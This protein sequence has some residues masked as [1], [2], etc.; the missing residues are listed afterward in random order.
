MRIGVTPQLDRSGGGVYQYSMGLLDALRDLG[1]D[2]E[3]VLFHATGAEVPQWVSGNASW[4]VAELK[5]PRSAL[6]SLKHAGSVTADKVTGGRSGRF[7]DLWRLKRAAPAFSDGSVATPTLVNPAWASW[8]SGFNL[9]LMVMPACS[10][11]AFELGI[12]FIVAV[13]DLQHRLQP[14][15][16]EVSADGEWELREYATRGCVT[17]ALLVLVDSEVGREDVLECYGTDGVSP[18]AIVVLP[19]Q[20]AVSGDDVSPAEQQRVRDAHSLSDPYF[21]Y[22]AQFWSHKNHKRIIEALGEL[23][24]QGIEAQLA[25]AGSR[26]G[27]LREKTFAD[28]METAAKLGIGDNVR[29]MGYVPDDDMIPLYA[30]AAALVMPTFFGPTNIPVLEAWGTGCP[31]ITSDIRGIREQVGDAGLLV[32]PRSSGSIARGMKRILTEP[33]LA[34]ALRRRGRE[35]LTS[36]TPED[37]TRNLGV[38]LDKAES[39]LAGPGISSSHDMNPNPEGIVDGRS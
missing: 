11:L 39:L 6:G 14:E 31:V 22:P 4:T 7:V 5:L 27:E 34:D 25:L 3:Y 24:E 33:D 15:F 21:F 26:T 20:P 10:P 32:D 37:F 28:A 13:H 2:N 18:D 29:Y 17:N 19:F 36:F 8:F 23:H 1:G 35:R 16:P 38:I 30:A 12:P 9:G